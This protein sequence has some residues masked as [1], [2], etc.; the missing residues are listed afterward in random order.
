MGKPGSPLRAV[1]HRH[2]IPSNVSGWWHDL[3]AAGSGGSTYVH[4][5]QGNPA[6]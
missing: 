6:K 5:L 2:A 3:I 1:L 4:A